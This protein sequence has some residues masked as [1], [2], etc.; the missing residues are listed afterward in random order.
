VTYRL[1]SLLRR[2]LRQSDGT[3]TVEFAIMF[4]LVISILLM[5]VEAGWTAVQRIAME[6]AIDLTVRDV[7]LGRLPDDTS[8]AEFRRVV[9]GNSILLA[10]C[11]ERLLL[12]MREVDQTTW[13]FPTERNECIDLAD[14]PDPDDFDDFN[15]GRGNSLMYLRACYLIRPIFPTTALGLQLPLD[16]SGMFALR[17]TTGFVR[18]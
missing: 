7:R 6:R 18:E 9:C 12:E 17:T 5:G 8:H 11:E 4:P 15:L 2:F 13:V 16:A 14:T 10:D 1:A 3:A